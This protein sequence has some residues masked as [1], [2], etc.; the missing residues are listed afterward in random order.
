MAIAD[1]GILITRRRSIAGLFI[2]ATVQEV[3]ISKTTVTQNP[4]E[5]GANITDHGIRQPD[6]Y[7]VAGRISDIPIR[8]LI[9]DPWKNGDAETRSKAAWAILNELK[10]AIEPFTIESGLQRYENMLIETLTAQ[11]NAR[12]SNVLD[13]V[14]ECTQVI[15]V[16]TEETIVGFP[17][18]GSTEEQAS[19]EVDRGDVQA[20]ELS[21]EIEQ[22]IA[23]KA[24]ILLGLI[25]GDTDTN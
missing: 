21:D 16:D 15:I 23:L 24:A 2:D 20:E 12:N 9:P 11:Q 7:R 22:S 6:K 17:Q 3:F 8:E 4:I 25:N 19:S 5:F 10:N 1:E 13:F 14:A 18:A